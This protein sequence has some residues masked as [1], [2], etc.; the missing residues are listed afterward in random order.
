MSMSEPVTIAIITSVT[1]V[2]VA[3]ITV[4][5]KEW[6]D[7]NK[8][9]QIKD[10]EESIHEVEVDEMVLVHDWIENF[11]VE[12]NFDTASIYQFHNGG[13]FFQGKSIKK[14]SMTYESV[15]PGYQKTKRM[16]QNILA[17]D[18]PKWISAMLKTDYFS[19]ITENLEQ[20]DRTELMSMGIRQAVI[21]PIMS[22]NGNLIGFIEGCNISKVDEE[23]DSKKESMIEDSLIIS[24]YL[25]R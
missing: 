19:V 3:L 1:S 11:R 23:I 2:V 25:H 16:K 17:T 7:D 14:F 13:K 5:V 22:L 12:Y 9:D 15:A 6:V 10:K 18:H 24:G 20:K 21:I 4:V 8:K